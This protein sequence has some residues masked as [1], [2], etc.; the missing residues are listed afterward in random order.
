ME[1]D[2]NENLQ[3]IVGRQNNWRS[4][5][6]RSQQCLTLWLHITISPN[7]V[8]KCQRSQYELGYFSSNAI[9]IHFI[10]VHTI[11]ACQWSHLCLFSLIKWSNISQS[12]I[13]FPSVV[14]IEHQLSNYIF[15]CR[16]SL[17]CVIYK[18]YIFI[19]FIP[20]HDFQLNSK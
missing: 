6:M 19:G 5:K 16:F 7:S 2:L 15:L 17:A 11:T 3:L 4:L 9:H 8:V 1:A 10:A 20:V 13:N 14:V 18:H 12:F